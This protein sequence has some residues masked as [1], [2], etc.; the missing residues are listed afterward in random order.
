[1]RSFISFSEYLSSIF[2]GRVQ[3]IA[4]NAGLGC[5][6]RDGRVGVGGCIF[7]NNAAFN[8]S[9]AYDS[10]GSITR[11]LEDGVRFFKGKG[12]FK[13]IL[14]YFQSY[15]NTYGPTERLIS[16]YEE[17]LAFPGALGL[18]IATRPD[19][20]EPDLLDWFE[21]RFGGK[22]PSGHPYLLL[23]IG[24]ESTC[25]ET[26][27]R[28]NRG[29]DFECAERAI[30]DIASRGIAVG[31]HLILGLPGESEE[32]FVEHAR[33]ISE[34]PVTTLKLHQ[35]QVIK[36]TPLASMYEENPGCLKLMSPLEYARAVGGF[37]DN[38]REDIVLD[39]FVSE[40]PRDM[41]LAP[42]WGLKPSEFAEI[43]KGI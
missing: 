32:D 1:M 22:A 29:H 37:V 21:R 42:A 10:A 38:L 19:C 8:P 3:K 15:S 41:V 13:G 12:E 11:Q 26:L 35:L 27:R 7:C 18:V 31:V 43:L 20:L 36:G 23:E 40:T 14:P 9:Y 6:N 39:R 2:S 16:L 25:D 30:R 17:A 24:V 5:P 28:I 34:L 33:R 4:V